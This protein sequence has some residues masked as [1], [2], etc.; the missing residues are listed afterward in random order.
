MFNSKRHLL[1]IIFLSGLFYFSCNKEIKEKHYTIGFSQCVASDKWRQAML[2][3]MK[4]EL[5]F[6]D[7]IQFIYKDADGNSQK[8]IE[9]VKEL[10][11]QKIDLLIISPNEANPL[12]P[13]VKEV[14][15]NGTPVIVIDRKISSA[16]YTA[17]LG[18]D[19]YQIGYMA[20]DYAASLLNRKG[21]IIEISGLPGSSPA[22]ERTNGFADAINKYPSLKI[23][24]EISGDWVKPKAY[25]GLLKLSEELKSTGLIFAQNDVMAVGAFEALKSLNQH[26]HK[27]IIGIDAL[28]GPDAGIEFIEN[29]QIT[30]SLL[31]PTGGEEAIQL[32]LKILKRENFKKENILPTLVV[33][34]TNVRLMKLQTDKINSQQK[35]IEKQQNIL[36]E[37]IR[38]YKNQRT[39]NNIL[40]TA[41]FLVVV[42][43]LIVYFSWRKNKRI[44][45]KLQ[46][47]NEEISKQSNQLIELSAKTEE[48]H[49]AR[50]NFFTNIS[51]EFRTPL[52]LILA[53]LEELLSNPRIHQEVKQSLQ[54]IQRNGVRLYRLIDQLMDFRKIEF[55]K[56]PMQVSENDII[57][58][59]KYIVDAYK[60]LAKNKNIDLQ[61][62]TSE[63]K[64]DVWFDIR[65]LDKVIFNLMSNAFKFTKEDGFV[66]VTIMKEKDH[67]LIKIEDD[68]IGMT[69]EVI[70]HAFDPF[71]QG[72]YENYKGT[73]LGLALSKELIELHQGSITVKS[74]KR[75]GSVF[76]ISLMLGNAHFKQYE[77]AT[78]VN[79]N[80][81]ISEDVGIYTIDLFDKQNHYKDD[82]GT[83][84]KDH[85]L[86]IIEDNQEMREYLT[87]RFSIEYNVSGAENGNM[88][89]Q[90]GFD[91]IPDLIICDIVIPGKNGLELTKIFKKD[92]RTSHIPVIL[93]TARDQQNQKIEGFESQADAYITKPFNLV[94][95]Q[96]T[97]KSL[98]E[99]REK[100][101]GHYSGE[102]FSEAKSQL[103]KKTDRKFIIDFTGVVENN[104]GNEKFG[105]NDICKELGISRI[106]LYRKIKIIL[107]CN[108]NDYII[109]TRLQKAKYYMQHE[110]LTI[111]EIAFKSGFSSAAYFSTVFKSKFGLTPKEFKQKL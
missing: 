82:S 7:N 58:F 45:K 1:L 99:N 66:H 106:Q 61:L 36:S 22:M 94:F 88:G 48:A 87:S 111:S 81:T 72:E 44:S 47:Q 78:S 18:A 10:I 60:L 11:D 59:T 75:K 54:L 9:Q 21:N 32:A 101:K 93:L 28:S 13:I 43:G 89:L 3:G 83:L 65:M 105:V 39:F 86:L 76:V 90:I 63:R 42:L 8:Q 30:A 24:N 2:E 55:N 33:D 12:T 85:T 102:I 5:A 95:L 46:L 97:V 107:N 84:S 80:L 110:N 68:G 19:N 57:G 98:L 16:S 96:K 6:H 35:E 37:Q 73:G 62:I 71:F 77:L 38:I 17:Y 4:R 69:K 92:I 27:K 49:Q 56:M 26:E 103:S 53:P 41:L 34:S 52:T 50:I 64:L 74:E 51:H 91:I 40:I 70:D 100:I 109:T 15:D 23:I 25:E 31:Y 108:V 104:I 29:H 67:A 20:G 79:R 14:Y